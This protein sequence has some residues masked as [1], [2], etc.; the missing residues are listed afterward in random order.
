MKRYIFLQKKLYLKCNFSSIS[1]NQK[2]TKSFSL[3]CSDHSSLTT[4]EG[5]E[6]G[7]EDIEA[8]GLVSEVDSRLPPLILPPGPYWDVF[9][10][11]IEDTNAI[12]LR[13]LGEKYSVSI[14]CSNEWISPLGW[15]GKSPV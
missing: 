3:P 15:T 10:M 7:G 2:I 8:Q 4:S 6:A 9:I 14:F 5:A 13:L 12:F 1:N 11:Y